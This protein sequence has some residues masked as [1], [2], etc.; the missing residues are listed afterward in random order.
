MIESLI[1]F[2]SYRKKIKQFHFQLCKKGPN[3]SA[4]HAQGY[5]VII[6]DFK[7]WIRAMAWQQNL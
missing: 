7:V 6:A 3:K 4:F 2:N 5:M 1:T